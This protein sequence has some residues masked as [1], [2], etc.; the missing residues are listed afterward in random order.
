MINV[1]GHRKSGL[2]YLIHSLLLN[3]DIKDE[4]FKYYSHLVPPLEDYITKNPISLYIIRDG[5]DVLIHSYY[6]Y[7]S[8]PALLK[9]FDGISFRQYLFGEVPLPST[10]FFEMVLNDKN[11]LFKEQFTNPIGYW[12][13]HIKSYIDADF[14]HMYFVNFELLCTSPSETLLS[15]ADYY[16]LESKTGYIVD[17]PEIIGYTKYSSSIGLWRSHFG[18]ADKRYFWDKAGEFM[19]ELGYSYD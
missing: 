11:P 4:I 19:I 2:T 18:P 9:F 17:L 7:K 8:Q 10:R 14:K 3:F 6:W 1:F 16:S 15:I 13:R 12:V 5:R